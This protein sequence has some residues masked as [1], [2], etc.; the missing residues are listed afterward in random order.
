MH[1]FFAE[2]NFLARKSSGRVSRILAKCPDI[3]TV[4]EEFVESRNIG[5]DAWRKTGVLTFDGNA[6]VEK[7]VTFERIRQHLETTYKRKFSYGIQ[8][9]VQ[10]NVIV[11]SS[12]KYIVKF[13]VPVLPG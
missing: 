8:R 11:Q 7:K 10:H 9:E 6:E 2:K 4:I 13:F 12:S 3:A 5:A 1:F